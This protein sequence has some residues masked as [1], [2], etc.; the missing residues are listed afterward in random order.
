DEITIWQSEN[1]S[2]LDSEGS[3]FNKAFKYDLGDVR[4]INGIILS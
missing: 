1:L 3:L 4:I 2:L